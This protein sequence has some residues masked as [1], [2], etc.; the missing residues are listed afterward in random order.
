MSGPRRAL[1]VAALVALALVPAIA[2]GGVWG[3]A[4]ANVSPPTTTT[5]TTVPVAPADVLTTSIMSLRRH[6]TPLAVAVAE[7]ES[8]RVFT[9]RVAALTD[10][11][12]TAGCVRLVDGDREI[13]DLNDELPLV[14][15][16]NQKLLVAA[17]A[18]DVL[19]P[20]YR[21]RTELQSPPPT[22]EVI[23]G[24]VFLVGG[25][26]P[27]LWTADVPDPQRYP[28]F[29][30][31]AL[32]P[33]VDR[34]VILG[35]TTIDGDIVGDGSRYD[36]EFRAPSWGPDITNL[37]AGPYDALLVNDGL[38]TEGNYGLDP[39]RSAARVFFD[40][41]V[42]RGITIT[43]TPA[44][45]GR[46][47][48]A[49]LTTLALVESRALTD[50]LVE[51]LHTSDNNT[52][53]ML[54]KEI[55]YVAAGEGTRAAGLR[56]IAETLGAWD[57]PL[58]GVELQDGS[59]LSRQNR[60]TCTALAA[61]M[62]ATPVSDELRDLLPVAGRD[63]TLAMQLLGTEAEGRLQA[64]TGTLTGVKALS[65]SQRSDSRVRVDFSLLL[66]GDG[67]DDPEVYEPVW[68]RIVALIA[69]YPVTIEPDVDTFAPR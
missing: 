8:E 49:G 36:D 12:G 41:V 42:A 59:G 37:D 63:G 40:M 32:E 2:L 14:P 61:V 3:Y 9:E 68:K 26:D 43:G 50:V 23:A 44:N 35:I 21:F 29:N 10:E 56:V 66:N 28:A 57:V 46:P 16:S 6:P 45:S 64:K 27:V 22:G 11:I 15:A 1:P 67:V 31:T 53:E 54:V 38:I 52:A 47:L 58:V 18:L 13:A 25:G 62:S 69:G 17:V 24:D 65:G 48:D 55:G 39:N 51:M 7:S 20:A 30:T 4:D 34:L 33:L 5:T 60:L 19:G